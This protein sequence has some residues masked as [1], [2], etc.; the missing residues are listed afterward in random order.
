M[1]ENFDTKVLKV[2][3]GIYDISP[4]YVRENWGSEMYLHT[5]RSKS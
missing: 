4:I 1:F 3:L 2:L 5:P